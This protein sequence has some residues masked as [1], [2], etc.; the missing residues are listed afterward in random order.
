MTAQRIA[1]LGAGANGASIGAD[2]TRAGL[3][4]TL[5]EQWPAHVARMRADGVRIEMPEETLV[6]EVRAIDLC[7]VAELRRPFDVVLVLVKAYDTRWAAELI[8][9]HVAPAGLVAGVQNGMTAD[10]LAAVVGPERAIGCVIEVSSMMTEPGVV[11]RHSPP[12]RSWFAVG[13]LGPE[14]AGREE[15]V[16]AL[17]RH[18]GTVAVVPNIRAAKWMK[19]VSNCS[20]LVPTAILGLPML[21]ALNHEQM[22]ELMLAAGQEALDAGLARG[23]EVLPIFGLGAE[24]VGDHDRVVEVM[25]D[26]LYAGFVLEQT[27][28]TVL[29]DWRKGRHSEVDDVNGVVVAEAARHGL[30]APV[31][32]ALVEVGHRIER[33]ELEP[34]PENYALLRRL[35]GC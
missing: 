18:A 32:A 9:P 20:T 19:L 4:V 34:A 16:A 26:R 31:N 8:A 13:S 15:E 3:D 12:S 35:S 7:E 22:R 21:A 24:D 11:E 23:H 30:E 27:T 33:G 10:D 5:I 14:T 28:T 2:L 17:L 1:V 25:L 6:Q 29:H